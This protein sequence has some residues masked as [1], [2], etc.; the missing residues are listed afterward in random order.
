[1]N[2]LFVLFLNNTL[3]MTNTFGLDQQIVL[4]IELIGR[5]NLLVYP[6]DFRCLSSKKLTPNDL[7]FI[8]SFY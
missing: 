6:V 7:R 8:S 4:K 5:T 1:M 2:F 3:V